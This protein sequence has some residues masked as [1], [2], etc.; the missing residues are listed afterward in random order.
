MRPQNNEFLVKVNK[1]NW[2]YFDK[3]QEIIVAH[4][5]DQIIPSLLKVEQLTTKGSYSAGFI[6]YEA[7]PAFDNSLHC[8]DKNIFPLLWFGIYEQPTHITTSQLLKLQEENK[9]LVKWDL[10]CDFKQ[11]EHKIKTI[12]QRIAEGQTYQVN[13]TTRLHCDNTNITP[14]DFFLNQIAPLDSEYSAF[15]QSEEFALASGSPELF[16]EKKGHVLKSKPMKGTRPRGLYPEDDKTQEISLRD[17]QKDRAENV[18]IVDMIRN[19]MGKVGSDKP[20]TTELFALEKYSTV[21][22]MTSTVETTTLASLPEIFSALFPCASITGAPKVQTMKIIKELEDEPRGVYTGCI[23]YITPQQDARFN[24]AI[25][26]ATFNKENK[27]AL[28]GVGGGIVWDSKAKDEYA[29][30][31]TKAAILN[32]NEQNDFQLLETML[33]EPNN[34]IF[35]LEEHLRRLA[36]SCKYFNFPYDQKAIMSELK[37][38]SS[39]TRLRLRLLFNSDGTWTLEKNKFPKQNPIKPKKWLLKLAHEP[40]NSTNI[41]LYHKTTARDIYNQARAD[42]I[43]KVDDVVLY[44][45]NNEVTEATIANIV[46]LHNGKYYT[47]QQKSGLLNGT[48]RTH[49]IERGEIEERTI[50]V[51]ELK[52]SK[53]IWLIN[54]VRKWIPAKL[55]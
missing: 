51:E 37:Q 32:R 17:S 5:I 22:Q 2:L 21:W 39:T 29:E 25:R 47:P 11:Y 53:K 45:E 15:W 24:V 19:D 55:L 9:R 6:S 49:L 14:Y 42:H 33:Y 41:L 36:S 3:L 18:M 10:N 1:N 48:F 54:S 46:I 50:T 28:Y 31:K 34:G 4:T 8:N 13:Y 52:G 26:T 38:L 23:G 20:I 40:I 16:F 27:T 12:K 30:C 35:L 43:D 44:N 7:A